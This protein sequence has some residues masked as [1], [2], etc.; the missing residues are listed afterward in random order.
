MNKSVVEKGDTRL[1]NYVSMIF[2][3]IDAH[4]FNLDFYDAHIYMTILTMFYKNQKT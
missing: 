4:P 3:Q 1:N 2:M